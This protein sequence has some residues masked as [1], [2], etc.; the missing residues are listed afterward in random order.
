MPE[1]IKERAAKVQGSL[2][3]SQ[4]LFSLALVVQNMGK[5]VERYAVFRLKQGCPAKGLGATGKIVLTVTAVAKSHPGG[6][7]LRP[8]L[9]GRT[10]PSCRPLPLVDPFQAGNGFKP[11]PLSNSSRQPVWRQDQ[12]PH[13]SLRRQILRKT[14]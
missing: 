11:I 13:D 2:C 6:K 12:E 4:G 1:I 14:R 5:V 8:A 9:Q 7:T 10:I 3:R